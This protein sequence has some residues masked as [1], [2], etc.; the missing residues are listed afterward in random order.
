MLEIDT[1][2]KDSNGLGSMWAKCA[3][4]ELCRVRG[5]GESEEE[6]GRGHREKYRCVGGKTNDLL[7][8]FRHH[9]VVKK[10]SRTWRQGYET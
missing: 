9:G 6:A 8:P 2:G 7:E 1:Y 4:P 3:C 5:G 10:K